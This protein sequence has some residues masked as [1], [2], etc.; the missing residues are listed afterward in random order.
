MSNSMSNADMI[1]ENINFS[2]TFSGTPV[3]VQWPK[4][5]I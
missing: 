4:D 1:Q 2:L 3:K 5:A